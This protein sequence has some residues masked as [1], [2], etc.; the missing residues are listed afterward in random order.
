MSQVKLG[1]KNIP[2]IYQGN[3]LLYPNPIKDG[4]ILWTDFKALDNNYFNKQYA[5]N[6]VDNSTNNR[7]YNFA[8]KV[9]SGYSNGLQ[10]DGVD[11]FLEFSNIGVDKFEGKDKFTFDFTISFTNSNKTGAV[12]CLPVSSREDGSRRLAVKVTENKEIAIGRFN[13]SWV[14]KKTAPITKERVNIVITFEGMEGDDFTAKSYIDGV[15]I[16]MVSNGISLG[17]YYGYPYNYLVMGQHGTNSQLEY[18][19]L[20]EIIHSSKI[21][22]RVLTK[23]ELEHN[24]QLEKERWG[25]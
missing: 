2:F 21:Y 7:L 12:Y 8:Y 13:G 9:G 5:E 17:E 24:Y 15:P 22:N 16:E 14:G 10:F 19:F 6:F 11:D 3:E 4:L 25:L 18:S 23:Q 20:K 1:D